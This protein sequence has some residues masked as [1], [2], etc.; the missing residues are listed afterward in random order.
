MKA[1]KGD[2]EGGPAFLDRDELKSAGLY[3][4][5]GRADCEAAGLTAENFAA[6]WA[7]RE[8]ERV[9]AESE[10]EDCDSSLETHGIGRLIPCPF[11]GDGAPFES[12][13]AILASAIA[14]IL[15]VLDELAG[16]ATTDAMEECDR[17]GVD[18]TPFADMWDRN[19]NR[20]TLAGMDRR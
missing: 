9:L 3:C 13:D 7:V 1:F 17:L 4:A 14:A 8:A 2:I 5:C 15:P 18:F 12:A 11:S 20:A 19:R 10:Q 6:Q 16:D